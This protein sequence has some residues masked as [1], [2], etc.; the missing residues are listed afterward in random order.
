MNKKI[1]IIIPLYNE[2]NQ[3]DYTAKRVNQV[4]NEAS[5]TFDIFFIDDGST[6]NTWKKILDLKQKFKYIYGIKLSR[7]FGKEHA[8]FAGLENIP[9]DSVACVILDADLQFPPN[10]IPKMYELWEKQGYQIIEGIK[11]NKEKRNLIYKIC[12]KIYYWILKVLTGI[13][14]SQASD[15]KFLDINAVKILLNLQERD[16]YFRGLIEWIGLR[17]ISIPFN[18]EERK[19]G[20]SKWSFVKL[21]KLSISSIT[22]FSSFPLQ[23]V[24]FVGILFLIFSIVLGAHTIVNW[25]LHRSVEG[26]TTVILLILIT[27]SCIMISLG[28]IGIYI[29]KIF[30][31]VKKRPKFI[32]CDTV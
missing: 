27:G 31:E 7:N 19:Y 20:K 6:D 18:V 8:I 24:T 2:E 28:I 4:L 32:V 11:I 9:S 1:T 15:F 5:I 23:I 16:T 22:S 17:K 13:Q 3:I 12:S 10:V 29:G 21:I 30:E 26:F 25:I 14:F